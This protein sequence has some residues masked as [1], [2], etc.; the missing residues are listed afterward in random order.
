VRAYVSYRRVRQRLQYWRSTSGFEVDLI[1]GHDL[2]IEIK[3]TTLVADKHLKGLRALKEEGLVKSY[4]AVSLDPDR[5][6]TRDG[7]HI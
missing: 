3:S 1:I 2:A 4:C 5:R 7:I 6:E